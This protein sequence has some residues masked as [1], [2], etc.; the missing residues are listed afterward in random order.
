MPYEIDVIELKKII[1]E[2]HIKSISQL[3]SI[4]GI[5]RHTLGRILNKGFK[6]NADTMYKLVDGLNMSPS[7][8]RNIFFSIDLN[9]KIK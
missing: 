9:N 5:N 6:P 4:C 3:S 2:R 7:Q 1:I 8:A